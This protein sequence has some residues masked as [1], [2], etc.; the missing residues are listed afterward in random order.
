MT[1]DLDADALEARAH[2][3]GDPGG[4][5]GVGA[6][7]RGEFLAAEPA[8]HVVDAHAV[9]HRGGEDP[10]RLVAGRVT[11]AVVDRLEVI[12][13]EHHQGDRRRQLSRCRAD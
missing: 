3:L 10:Q 9:A 6:D 12:E 4:Y 7:D 8:D 2:A 1:G 13:I 5:L 11:E